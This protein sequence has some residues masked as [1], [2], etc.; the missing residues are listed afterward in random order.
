MEKSVKFRN[1]FFIVIESLCKIWVVFLWLIL[2]FISTEPLKKNVWDIA[3]TTAIIVIDFFLSLF[4]WRKTTYVFDENAL[5][6]EKNA[7]VK[8]KQTIVMSNITTVNINRTILQ[9]IFGVRLV[10]VDTNS[11]VSTDSEIK[12]YLSKKD[13]IEFQKTIMEF[14]SGNK[15]EPAESVENTE[16]VNE[17]TEDKE[18]KK[19]KVKNTSQASFEEIF[20]HCI[21]TLKIMQIVI[22]ALSFGSAVLTSADLDEGESAGGVMSIITAAILIVGIIISFLQSK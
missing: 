5:V 3:I 22:F 16:M 9:A 18:E 2:Q 20:F 19:S 12:I 14:V 13:A 7:F 17:N 21:F 6:V 11:S 8:K 15:E 1:H 4:I 10:K